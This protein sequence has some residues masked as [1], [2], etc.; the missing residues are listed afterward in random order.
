M[1]AHDVTQYPNIFRV[2]REL[3]RCKDPDRVLNALLAMLRAD[4]GRDAG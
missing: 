1:S 3:A 4:E 2:D